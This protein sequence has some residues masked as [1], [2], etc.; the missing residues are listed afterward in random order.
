MGQR[1]EGVEAT[2]PSQI[3]HRRRGRHAI[4]LARTLSTGELFE[5]FLLKVGLGGSIYG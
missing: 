5:E 4:P 2:T 3:Q 1:E